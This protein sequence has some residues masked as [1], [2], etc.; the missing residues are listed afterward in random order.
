M[1]T[2][3]YMVCT[4]CSTYNQ[5]SYIESALDGFVMQQV[6]FPVVFAIID[7]C[8]TDGEQDIIRKW[9]E[10]NLSFPND[11]NAYNK[12][13]EYGDLF[14]ARHKNNQ[15][16]QFAILL[17]SENLT[18]TG[19]SHLRFEYISQWMND[20][21]Y[22]AICEGDDYWTNPQKL[23]IQCEFLN[24]HPDY[25]MCFHKANVVIE[26]GDY[27]GYDNSMYDDLEERDYSGLELAKRWQVPTASILYRSTIR[28][29]HDKK[30]LT[31]DI[32]LVLQCA[33]EGR[34][35]C[36]A[37]PMSVYRRTSG[38]VT[39]NKYTTLQIVDKLLAYIRYFPPF[40]SV[41]ENALI[42][43]MQTMFYSSQCINA[44]KLVIQRRSLFYY[45]VVGALRGVIQMPQRMFN[46]V[47]KKRSNA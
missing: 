19:R 2:Y 37:E 41:Y 33:L 20:S 7:D 3:K 23:Q 28:R 45:F 9:V 4:R 36:F 39:L 40:K 43:I 46:K 1:N 24:T 6:N 14:F 11:I 18:Q 34:V 38:G 30:L 35:F 17:L 15:N 21:K 12:K 25:S 5:A 26:S 8:S 44:I 31:G 10:I 13:M 42:S 27:S 22:L 29:P 47:F 16:L 32:P